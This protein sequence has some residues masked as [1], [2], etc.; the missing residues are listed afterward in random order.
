MFPTKRYHRHEHNV[1]SLLC[2]EESDVGELSAVGS[3]GTPR[4]TTF[5]IASIPVFTDKFYALQNGPAN[6][7]QKI[8]TRTSL[9]NRLMLSI[10]RPASSQHPHF[11]LNGW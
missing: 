3:P 10:F 9:N 2:H 7:P 1:N 11:Y 8:L 4:S 6:V 5:L